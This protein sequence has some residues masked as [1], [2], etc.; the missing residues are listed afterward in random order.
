M[1]AKAAKMAYLEAG[2]TLDD[3]DGAVS[4]EEDLISGYSIADEYTPD[5]LGCVRKP[6]YTITGDF[7]H[8]LGSAVMQIQTGQ[9]DVLVVEAY[10][11]ASSLLTRDELLRFAYDPVFNR[12]GASPHWLAGIEMRAFLEESGWDEADIAEVVI[13]N[14]AEAVKNPLAAYG[15]TYNLHDVLG[16][17]PVATPVTELMIARP[18]DGAVVA[19]IGSDKAAARFGRKNV[20]IAGVGWGSGTSILE[21]RDH[22]ESVGTSL[23][24]DMAYREARIDNPS[25]EIDA[26]FVSDLYAHRQLVHLEALQ[27]AGSCAAPVNPGGGSLGV[28][29]L[30]ECNGAARFYEAVCQLRGEAGQCQVDARRA[31]VHGWRGLPTDSCAV[32]ILEAEGR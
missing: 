6:V 7:L 3:I 25:H 26:F 19:V 15:A 30:Y 29:D 21:R 1:I 18:A 17:R 20:R 13:R 24:A 14:R 4:N 10:S 5:Q 31:L 28:G 8:G 9:F 22:A 11:K 23:A 12:F 16:A 32:A 27:V 2:V